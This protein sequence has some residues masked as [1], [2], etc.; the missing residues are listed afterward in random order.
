VRFPEQA[1]TAGVAEP[2]WEIRTMAEIVELERANILRVL[3]DCDFRVSGTKGATARMGMPPATS[4][5]RME[6]LGIE[7]SKRR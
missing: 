1:A 3:E 2:D 6:S 5:S 7:R 4:S